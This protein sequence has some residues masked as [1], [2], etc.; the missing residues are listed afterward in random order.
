[1]SNS[2]LWKMLFCSCDTIIFVEH[3]VILSFQ[4]VRAFHNEFDDGST[5][6]E[7]FN[8]ICSGVVKTGDFV[9]V[10]VEGG[11]QIIAQIDCIWEMKE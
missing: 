1:M 8:T 7:Q 6:Y 2:T 11:K 9:Y 3:V 4:N 5:Y 10:V